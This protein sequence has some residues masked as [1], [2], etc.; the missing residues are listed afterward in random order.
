MSQQQES[1]SSQGN[2]LLWLR[3]DLRLHDHPALRAAA[4]AAAEGNAQIRIVFVF[5]AEEDGTGLQEG[6]VVRTFCFWHPHATYD[7]RRPGH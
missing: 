5:S 4:A 2:Q 7:V 3:Q 1:A 6:E